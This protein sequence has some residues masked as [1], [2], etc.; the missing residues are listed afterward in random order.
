MVRPEQ[1]K[2]EPVGSQGQAHR[3]AV[4]ATVEE[5]TF[6][7]HDATLSLRLDQY[8]DRSME[9]AVRARVPGHQVPATGV[10]VRLTVEGEVIAYPR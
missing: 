4:E 6:Y 5:I 3:D 1:I 8:S 2:V 10:R 9:A 7:G